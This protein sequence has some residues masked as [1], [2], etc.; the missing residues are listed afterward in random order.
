[1]GTMGWD[2]QFSTSKEDYT[3]FKTDYKGASPGDS[4][5]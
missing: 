5:V 2:S 1:M 4:A 3:A